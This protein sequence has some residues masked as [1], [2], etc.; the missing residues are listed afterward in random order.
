MRG[1][2]G[3]SMGSAPHHSCQDENHEEDCKEDTYGLE[4]HADRVPGNSRAQA[5]QRQK[6]TQDHPSEHSFSNLFRT[7][8]GHVEYQPG[9]VQ[10][11][12]DLAS[13]EKAYR[14]IAALRVQKLRE[15]GSLWKA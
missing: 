15:P 7:T 1:S 10:F 6:S 4:R 12:H 14:Q 11:Q 8:G 2:T 5:R 13:P 9:G 3:N